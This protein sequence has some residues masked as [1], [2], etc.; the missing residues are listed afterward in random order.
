MDAPPELGLTTAEQELLD[1]FDRRAPQDLPLPPFAGGAG[2]CCWLSLPCAVTRP[3]APSCCSYDDYLSSFVT[4]TDLK[5]LQSEGA[6]RRIV[7]LGYMHGGGELLRREE[8]EGRKAAL[9]AYREALLCPKPRQLLSAGRDLSAHPL[10]RA[11]ADRELPV[12]RGMLATIVF[13]R[14]KN[15][16]GQEVSGYIDLGQRLTADEAGMA[17]VFALQARLLPQPTDLSTLN[18]TSNRLDSCASANFEVVADPA[19]GL[20]FKN[21][22][23]RKVIIVDPEAPSPGDYTTWTEVGTDEYD[24]A[25]I[26]DHVIGR[27]T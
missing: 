19:T 6:A 10:L 24:Q 16:R 15:A 1:K 12:R 5:Y 9:A 11:L 7:E 8:F 13:L 2:A 18:W 14:C 22:R 26:F 20:A 17:A 3:C 27:R 23:D 21:K 4:P 25:V